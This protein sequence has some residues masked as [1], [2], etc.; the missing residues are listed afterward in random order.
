VGGP[1]EDENS[2]RFSSGKLYKRNVRVDDGGVGGGGGEGMIKAKKRRSF[3][4]RESAR[5]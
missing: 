4:G 3:K 2:L 1:I 5:G